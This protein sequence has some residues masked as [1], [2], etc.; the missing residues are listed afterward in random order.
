MVFAAT[1]KANRRI[2]FYQ[3]KIMLFRGVGRKNSG[4]CSFGLERK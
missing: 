3:V 4:A 1:I 2:S